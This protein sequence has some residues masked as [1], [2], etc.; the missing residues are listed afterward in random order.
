MFTRTAAVLGS[1]TLGLLAASPPASADAAIS[2]PT[3][4]FEQEYLNFILDH[5]YSGLRATELAAGTAAVGPT[6][7]PGPWPANPASFPPTA[8][9]GTNPVVLDVAIRSNTSQEQEINEGEMFLRDW[10][11]T[12]A[13]LNVPPSGQQLINTLETAAPGDPF[14]IAFLT[15]FSE[16]HIMAIGRS[17]EC[18]QRAGHAELR[19]YCGM[20]VQ[21]QT[22]DVLE[23]R[24][25]LASR[26]G[27]FI[28]TPIPGIGKVPEPV[29]WAMVL[30]GVGLFR[31][32]LRHGGQRPGGRRATPA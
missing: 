27:I 5:H 28:D 1:L 25:E 31:V 29:T 12:L 4:A 30:L 17:V 16:H 8:A 20:I 23:M 9:R 21:M 3:G 18:V 14:N 19:E 10:Y 7:P 32:T 22:E 2:G 15:N 24:G 13:E 11:G 6:V 26:Y